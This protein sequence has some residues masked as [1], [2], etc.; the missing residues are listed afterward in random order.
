MTP[1]ISL[2]SLLF[3]LPLSFAHID[4]SVGGP[5]LSASIPADHYHSEAIIAEVEQ[6]ID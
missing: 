6:E 1:T 2:L 3:I 4:T 5:A